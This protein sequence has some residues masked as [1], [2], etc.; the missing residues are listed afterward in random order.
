MPRSGIWLLRKKLIASYLGISAEFL[1]KIRKRL[2]R[3]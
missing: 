1:S 3:K 2:A